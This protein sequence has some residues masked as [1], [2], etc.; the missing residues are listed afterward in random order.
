M[1]WDWIMSLDPHW[2][3]TLF[4]W[5]IFSSMFVSAITTI[6]LVTIYLKT[7]GY[8]VYVNNSHIHDLAK[9]MFGFSI[10]W[11]YLWFSQFMIIWYAN[12]PEE[13][14][15]FITRMNDYKLP[16]LGMIGLN[17]VF[18]LLILMNSDYKKVYGIIIVTGIV[19]LFGHYLDIF[20]MIMPATVGNQWAIGIPE[21][22]SILLFLGCF[23][24]IVFNA[25]SKVPLLAKGN[26]FVKESKNF[27]YYNID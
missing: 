7:K 26:P 18:P 1:S 10:F 12:I 6:A 9:Y 8:L 3:S 22:S 2:Y 21:I 25:L 17:L 16:F 24:Y 20:V 13:V 4:G 19:I 23:I 11:A 27:H 5:Y 14:T 15:Y